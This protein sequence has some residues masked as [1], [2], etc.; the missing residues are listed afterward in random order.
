MGEISRGLAAGVTPLGIVGV[1]GNATKT[2]SSHRHDRLQDAAPHP[3]QVLI[4]P[5]L[6]AMPRMIGCM[7]YLLPRTMHV[8]SAAVSEAQ[9]GFPSRTARAPD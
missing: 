7:S 4:P 9:A 6:G 8:V 3:D 1:A 5:V 2:Y